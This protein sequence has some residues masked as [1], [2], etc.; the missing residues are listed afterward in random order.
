MSGSLYDLAKG[1]N[2]MLHSLHLEGVCVAIGSLFNLRRHSQDTLQS[3][4]LGGCRSNETGTWKEVF[5]ELGAHLL[6]LR[7][8]E[9]SNI[10]KEILRS[11]VGQYYMALVWFDIMTAEE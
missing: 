10:S 7:N 5:S 6:F 2:M 1:V 8:L 11:V 4:S 9:I 3:F